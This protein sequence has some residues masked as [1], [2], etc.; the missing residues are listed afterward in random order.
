MRILIVDDEA[1]LRQGLE[2]LIRAFCPEVSEV[3]QADGV[4]SALAALRESAP[5]VL[6]LDVEMQ[7]GTGLQLVRSLEEVP[8]QVIFITAHNKYAVDAFRLSAIDFL[9]KP[10][11]PDQLV[12]ALGKARRNLALA[13]QM[14]ALTALRERTDPAH[15]GEKRIALRDQDQIHLVKTS[16]VLY[17][18]ADGS[19]TRFHL[20]S[21]KV[22]LVSRSLKEYEELLADQGFLRTH[23]SFLVNL[24]RVTGFNKAD[25]GQLVMENEALVPV[26]Q[27]KKDAVLEFFR[28]F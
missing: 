10:V 21:Q 13:E 23:H 26:S 2:W 5:D 20:V 11:E 6:M 12:E 24:S 14:K 16:D 4:A 19:Y 3:R 9:Q 17:C 18:E 25:G 1:H 27:R 22:V 28:Q 8:F 15:T 7:D